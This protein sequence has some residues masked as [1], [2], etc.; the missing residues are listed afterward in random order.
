MLLAYWALYLPV[1][2]EEVALL[3]RQYPIHR[4]L[5]LR[6]FEPLGAPEADPVGTEPS[7]QEG[8]GGPGA[9]PG[10]QADPTSGIAIAFESV[11]VRAAGHTILQDLDLSIEPASHIA[12]VGASGAGKSSLVGL[13]LGWHRAATG[14]VLVDGQP[15]D[16]ERL[17]GLRAETVWID[18][19]VQLWNRPLLSNLTY[20]TRNGSRL[21]FAQVLDDL[22]LYDLLQR[23][24]DG[25]QTHLGE[26]GGLISG[27]EGQRV[28][29]GRGMLRAEA[30]LVVLDE[31]FRGL[32]RAQRRALLVRVRELWREATLLCITHDMH[33]TR[34]FP[35]VLVIASGRVVQDGSPK[36]LAADF[37]SPYR[38]LLDGEHEVTRK[39]WSSPIWRRQRL[40]AGRLSGSG[41]PQ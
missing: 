3:V 11:T 25:L 36:E 12:I 37:G 35:R 39:L 21:P 23:L 16:P 34:D 6:L 2:G 24:P 32:E 20:G 10:S 15:L 4:N 9:A 33:D 7:R 5:T 41:R 13:L 38:A 40:E 18:P 30:R 14:Q 1:L 31:P 28:R 27:G 22:G 26:G 17:D 8:Q 29:L 19:A